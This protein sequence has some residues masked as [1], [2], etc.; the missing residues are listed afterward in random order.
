MARKEGVTL[1]ARVRRTTPL[2]DIAIAV[3]LGG[4]SGVYIFNDSMRRWQQSEVEFASAQSSTS[5][6]T[7]DAGSSSASTPATPAAATATP[8][9]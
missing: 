2:M 6:G 9:Q 7:S 4:A 1:R 8:Q 3:V 5:S